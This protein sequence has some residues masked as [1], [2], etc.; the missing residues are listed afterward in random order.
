MQQ[1]RKKLNI[2]IFYKR[3]FKFRKIWKTLTSNEN[4]ILLRT[5]S[6]KSIDI[7]IY[8]MIYNYLKS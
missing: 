6:G 1:I 7:E 8:F 3:K 5:K 2:D 4:I